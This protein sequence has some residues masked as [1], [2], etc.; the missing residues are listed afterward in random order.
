MGVCY[1]A[2]PISL[3]SLPPN[4]FFIFGIFISSK[5]GLYHI[6]DTLGECMNKFDKTAHTRNFFFC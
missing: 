1:R 5:D 4:Y 2:R 3:R 6:Y